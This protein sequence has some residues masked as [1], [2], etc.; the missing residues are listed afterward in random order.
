MNY[1]KELG[2]RNIKLNKKI[3]ETLL[4]H[5]SKIDTIFSKYAMR[6]KSQSEDQVSI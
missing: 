1:A 2:Y 4:N 3:D 6:S 5:Y